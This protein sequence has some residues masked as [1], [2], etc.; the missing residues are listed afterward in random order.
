MW[1][2]RRAPLICHTELAV[3]IFF[4]G[5]QGAL[6]CWRIDGWN[7]HQARVHT[8]CRFMDIQPSQSWFKTGLPDLITLIMTER[9]KKT[10]GFL[11]SG[12][13]RLSF[14]QSIQTIYRQWRSFIG[15]SLKHAFVS[16]HCLVSGWTMERRSGKRCTMLLG[17]RCCPNELHMKTWW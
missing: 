14:N 13:I 7:T 16:G 2:Q 12:D 4:C 10:H 3:D 15:F 5:P 6:P 1:M 17:K 11:T 8:Y 9:Q